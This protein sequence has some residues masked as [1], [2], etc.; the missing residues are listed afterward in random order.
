MSSAVG[1]YLSGGHI[2]LKVATDVAVPCVCGAD[3]AVIV[4][5]RS[6]GRLVSKEL[7]QPLT[8]F[9]TL[10]VFFLPIRQLKASARSVT[11]YQIEQ[12]ERLDVICARHAQCSSAYVQPIERSHAHN[13]LQGAWNYHL[14]NLY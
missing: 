12:A 10:Q 7:P 13:H 1:E 9:T 6:V 4:Q 3:V 11:L 8:L 2:E 5:V 14:R